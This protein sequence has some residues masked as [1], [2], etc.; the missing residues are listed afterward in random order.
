VNLLPSWFVDDCCLFFSQS[1]LPFLARAG[2]AAGLGLGFGVGGFL[3]KG[4]PARR[5]LWSPGGGPGGEDPEEGRG[6]SPACGTR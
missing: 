2:V 4:Q 6:G 3:F 5:C 1:V